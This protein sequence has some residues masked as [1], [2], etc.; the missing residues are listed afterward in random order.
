MKR[1]EFFEKTGCGA[2]GIMLAHLGLKAGTLPNSPEEQK[3]K[4]MKLLAK[5]GK[6][7]EEIDDMMKKMEE[8]LPMVK[9]QCIKRKKLSDSV[10]L[11]YPG[12][13][14]S[15]KKKGVTVPNAPSTKKW[16]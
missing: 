14:L 15:R 7:K 3:E 5:M 11:S 2:A 9:E 12:V 10:T 6:S 1:R 13:R 8:M 16:S 4:I